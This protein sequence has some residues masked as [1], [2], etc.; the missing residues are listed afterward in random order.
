MNMNTAA[1]L[2]LNSIN[3]TQS[4]LTQLCMSSSENEHTGYFFYCPTEHNGFITKKACICWD[5]LWQL[6]CC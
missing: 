5:I 3:I 4:T 1:M 6:Q 2:K